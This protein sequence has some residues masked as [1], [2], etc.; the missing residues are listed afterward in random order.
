L[1][2]RWTKILKGYLMLGK[3]LKFLYFKIGFKLRYWFWKVA[4]HSMGGKIGKNVKFYEGI[5]IV[6]NCPGAVTIGDDVRILRG[7]TISTTPEG[8]IQIG[9]RVHIGEGS[10]I[11]SGVGIRIGDNVIIG[12]QNIIVDLD[13]RFQNLDLPINQQGMNGKEI[14]IEEDVWIAS[15]CVIIKGVAIGKGSV[16]AAG[17]VVNKNIPPYS[18]AAGVPAKVIKK[19]GES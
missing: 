5:R 4:I 6:G 18:V 2:K 15:Q 14:S 7:V 19:R 12:P 9:N 11:Y 1:E 16:I 13:H 8:K 3:I 10:V 17:S